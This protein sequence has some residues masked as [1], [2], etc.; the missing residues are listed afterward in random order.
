MR[1]LKND[2]SLWTKHDTQFYKEATKWSRKSLIVW[3]KE[4]ADNLFF[5][6]YKHMK[7]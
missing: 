1:A 7:R 5:I 3:Q 4:S 6:V 2:E